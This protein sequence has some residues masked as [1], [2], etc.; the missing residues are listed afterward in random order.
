MALVD[1]FPRSAT[2]IAHED[3]SVLFLGREAVI[4][5][6]QE[7]PVVGRK[8][9][10]AFCRSLSLRLREASDRIVALTSVSRPS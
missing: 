7:H 6:F 4:D 8:I 10:W 1:D 2:A 5:L 9:L 3:C